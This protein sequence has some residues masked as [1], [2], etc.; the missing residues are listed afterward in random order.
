LE[1]IVGGYTGNVVTLHSKNMQQFDVDGNILDDENDI[2]QF[3][4]KIKQDVDWIKIPLMTH[5]D[6][7]DSFQGFISGTDLENVYY[8]I[9]KSIGRT[10]DKAT[11]DQK[12][13]WQ[14]FCLNEA[15][16]F[17]RNFL[18]E[19]KIQVRGMK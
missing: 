9:G 2:A 14:E 7:H 8:A 16:D 1:N 6:W 18:L 10:L 3:A 17:A 5:G 19:N 13:K 11:D 12:N 4:K 15:A